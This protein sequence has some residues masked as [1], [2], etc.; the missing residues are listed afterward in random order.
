MND[1]L[2]SVIIPVYNAEEYIARALESV[3]NQTYEKL[4]IIVV[5]D[6]SDDNSLDICKRYAACDKRIKLLHK[7][8]G[9]QASARTYGIKR[10]CG[11][12]ITF[13]DA[14]DYIDVEAYANIIKKTDIR[15]PDVIAYNLIEEDNEPV[16]KKNKFS[17]KYYDYEEMQKDVYPYMLCMENF[18]EFG[19]LPNL[20][21][22]FIK[23][24][25]IK[26]AD[27]KVND[28]VRFGE[29]AD[30]CYRYIAKAESIQF[31]D[32][33][34][35]HYIKH[36]NTM[37]SSNMSIQSI[38]C[39]YSDLIDAFN[40]ASI[41]DIMHNQLID[42]I[43]FVTLLKCPEEIMDD[44]GIFKKKIALY[45]AGGFGMAL[46]GIYKESIICVADSNYEKYKSS[47]AVHVISIEQ[48]ADMQNEFDIVFIAVLNTDICKKIEEQLIS[49]GV[50]KKIVYFRRNY[51]A[52]LYERLIGT[53]EI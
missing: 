30:A 35:Y 15:M 48:L 7:Q 41:G 5:D 37:V 34:P 13:L 44:T 28:V 3:L 26:R 17:E 8:N 19:I 32:Y 29:D 23:S 25:L 42:Y 52:G 51:A 12:Y 24:E 10:A 6:G 1:I 2:I 9:G 21:C 14:D 39:L 53:Q 40:N 47:T 20:V 11:D 33:A 31:L 16:I 50:K 49:K 46:Y 18:F 45:G 27:V 38:K 36:E 22:K 4:D 43:S